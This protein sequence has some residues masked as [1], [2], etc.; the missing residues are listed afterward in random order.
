MKTRSFITLILSL[1]VNA[2]LFGT[3]AII[4]LSIPS[5]REN[6]LYLIPAVIVVSFLLTP[7]ISWAIA[8]RVRARYWNDQ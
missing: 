1:V 7:F 3:G 2:L 6:M 8:P 5:L 4:V